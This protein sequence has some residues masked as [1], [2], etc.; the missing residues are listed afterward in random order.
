MAMKKDFAN[1]GSSLAHDRRNYRLPTRD[2]LYAG[3]LRDHEA[4][5]VG[6]EG[7]DFAAEP[8][9][10]ATLCPEEAA[11]AAQPIQ[12][13]QQQQKMPSVEMLKEKYKQQ[14]QQQSQ[15]VLM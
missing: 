10:F 7:I 12:G 13:K 4:Y 6:E 3:D 8:V 1:A 5:F 2:Q 11:K 15:L 9:I 14:Q